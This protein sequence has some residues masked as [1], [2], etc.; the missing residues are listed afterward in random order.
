MHFL[1]LNYETWLI[2]KSSFKIKYINTS[3]ESIIEKI[4]KIGDKWRNLPLI[5]YQ[6]ISMEKN[7]KIVEVSTADSLKDNYRVFKADSQK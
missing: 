3:N 2:T 6:L 5:L 1:K 7:S 4:I